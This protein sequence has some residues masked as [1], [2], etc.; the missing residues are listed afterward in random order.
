MAHF[1]DAG[2]D[3]LY[4]GVTKTKASCWRISRDQAFTAGEEYEVWVRGRGWWAGMG[5]SCGEMGSGWEARSTMVRV[6]LGGRA[7]VRVEWTQVEME[8]PI[9]GERVEQMMRAILIVG[10]AMIVW[11]ALAV[12]Q[13]GNVM[14]NCKWM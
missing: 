7:V 13:L 3:Q 5:V 10:S 9:L 11:M 8:G 12:V 1:T 2:N 4:W 14:R 6:V